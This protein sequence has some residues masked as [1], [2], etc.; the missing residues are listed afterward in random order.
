M[1]EDDLF[2]QCTMCGT[3]WATLSEFVL[4]PDLVVN[5]YQAHFEFPERGLAIVT[6]AVPDCGTTLAIPVHKL[7]S[8]YRGPNY[9]ERRTGTIACAGRCLRIE[10]LQACD[11]NC[12]MAWVR[13][14]IQCLLRHE[15]PPHL[16]L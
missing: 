1:P 14:A 13:H 4:D 11:A 5:G 10:D 8:L 2:K 6:H 7:R 15:L 16:N 9:R 12:D 3:Q